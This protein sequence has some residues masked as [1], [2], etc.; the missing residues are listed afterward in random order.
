[1][2]STYSGAV[3]RTTHLSGMFTD[4]GIFLGHALRG[5]PVDWL[6]MRL[7][8][9]I[10]TGFLSGGIAGTLAFRRLSYS[11]LFIPGG[12]AAITSLTYGLWLL[13]RGRSSRD[14]SDTSSCP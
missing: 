5:L 12:L 2:V 8:F 1:M 14:H 4:L 11:A 9:L 6:R 10:I 7:C 13:G 3:V